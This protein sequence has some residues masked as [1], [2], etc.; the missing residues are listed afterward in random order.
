MEP[1][2][3]PAITVK[4][5]IVI[6]HENSLLYTSLKQCMANN[7]ELRQALLDAAQTISALT[8]KLRE[9]NESKF[10]TT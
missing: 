3:A 6:T 9:Q 1:S 8:E 4:K 5:P 10:T 2:Q 7:E